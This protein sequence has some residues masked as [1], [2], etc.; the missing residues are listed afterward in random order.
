[1]SEQKDLQSAP[2]ETL[3]GDTHSVASGGRAVAR[4]RLQ[5]DVEAYL[6]EGG[7]IEEV[8]RDSRPVPAFRR[9]A[10]GRGSI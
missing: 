10:C 2:L 1:M 6:A 5:A 9:S 7:D 4:S 3:G 8:P